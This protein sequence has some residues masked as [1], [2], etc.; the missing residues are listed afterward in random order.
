VDGPAGVILI[1]ARVAATLGAEIPDALGSSIVAIGIVVSDDILG[2]AAALRRAGLAPV[3][4]ASVDCPVNTVNIHGMGVV[5]LLEPI[6]VLYEV[7]LRAVILAVVTVVLIPVITGFA[8]VDDA[9]GTV[10]KLA[11]HAAGIGQ[12]CVAR[13]F[14][15]LFSCLHNTISATV[16]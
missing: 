7:L 4:L 3:V 10:R 5:K 11:V 2:S 9:I 16:A 15:T 8:T 13:P 6:E 1:I 14:I 12:V